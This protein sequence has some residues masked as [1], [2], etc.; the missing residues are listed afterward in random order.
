MGQKK[1]MKDPIII[2][3]RKAID[4]VKFL[5]AHPTVSKEFPEFLII[6]KNSLSYLEEQV[7]LREE[8][9]KKILKDLE[10]TKNSIEIFTNE[11]IQ[12]FPTFNNPFEGLL[13]SLGI[14]Q[15][16]D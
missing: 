12:E 2:E 15:S 4:G 5:L 1:K 10:K 16:E 6:L 13:G 7:N 9:N 14:D 11:I 3:S 8:I